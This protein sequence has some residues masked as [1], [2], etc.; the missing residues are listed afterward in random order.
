MRRVR[1]ILRKIPARIF[2]KLVLV[3]LAAILVYFIAGIL[4]Y[5]AHI[6]RSL[7]VSKILSFQAAQTIFVFGA[8]TVILV[9]VFY[10][11]SARNLV[12]LREPISKPISFKELLDKGEHQNVEFKSSLR[13]DFKE[14]KV[15]RIIEKSV[16]KTVAAFLNS[17]GGNLVIGVDD[18][19]KVVG[20]AQDILTLRK[21]DVDGFENH[22]NNIFH[23]MIGADLRQ[24]VNLTYVREDESYC[25]IVSVAPSSNPAYLKTDD[26]EEFYIRT[27]NGT[28]SL[29]LSEANR[30]IQT[31]FI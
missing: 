17:E 9:F 5:Y 13:W 30:Y 10:R 18:N 14:N 19:K 1:E 3:E 4:A 2:G 29:K 28:T 31:R 15:N 25:C 7:P 22:F 26:N 6:Y 20:L 23:S 21:Q 27:G 16:M 12:H 24:Y 11:W 8:Q